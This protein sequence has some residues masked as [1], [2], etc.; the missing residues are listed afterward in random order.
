M[1]DVVDRSDGVKNLMKEGGI[2]GCYRGLGPRW[3]SM[4]MS[5]ATMIAT[6][7]FLKRLSTKTQ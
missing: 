4:S 5:A 1:E 7:E 2:G 3:A 6:I